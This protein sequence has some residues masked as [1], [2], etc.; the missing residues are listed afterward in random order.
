MRLPR[1]VAACLLGVALVV[2]AAASGEPTAPAAGEVAEPQPRVLVISVD[3]LNPDALRRLGADGAPALHRMLR[4]GA[5]T[6]NARSQVEQTITLPN[7]TSMLTGRRIARKHGGHGVTWTGHRP[8]TTVQKAAGHPVGSIFSVVHAAARQSALFAAKRKFSIFDRSWPAIDRVTIRDQ[9][10][11]ALVKAVRRDLV[12]HDRAFTFVHLG[13][14]DRA[15]HTHGFM[16]PA[17]LEA[18]R[19]TDARIDAIL[20]TV[21]THPELAE[22]LTVVVTSDHGGRGGG[23]SDP[24]RLADYRV[25]FLVRGP[26]V[27]PGDLYDL[28][29]GYRDPG[30]R[31]VL[32]RGRQ[33]VRNGDVANFAAS[34]LGLPP[35]PG[36][37]WDRDQGLRAR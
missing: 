10:D 12:D 19:R 34:L 37:L 27:V 13:D 11:G 36:S 18:V 35:V 28:N 30:A 33:P 24:A 5:G 31:R 4:E 21:D 9:R 1:V 2:P 20:H 23:H 22:R 16:G 15:G 25:P 3:G 32:F 6:L 26:D 8:G 14:V 7:H 29:P 17:Y